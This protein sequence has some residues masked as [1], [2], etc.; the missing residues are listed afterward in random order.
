VLTLVRACRPVDSVL[1]R[2]RWAVQKADFRVGRARVRLADTRVVRGHRTRNDDIGPA[3]NRVQTT[4]VAGVAHAPSCD[5][6][7]VGVGGT[8]CNLITAR[9]RRLKLTDTMEICCAAVAL[10][11]G[12]EL[13]I[14]A[15]AARVQRATTGTTR[16]AGR[17]AAFGLVIPCLFRGITCVVANRSEAFRLVHDCDASLILTSTRVRGCVCDN[18]GRVVAR[19]ARAREI[20]HTDSST[21]EF[22]T[23]PVSTVCRWAVAVSG[24]TCLTVMVGVAG[25]GEVVDQVGA[26]GRPETWRCR[27]LV[28][29]NTPFARRIEGRSSR[30]AESSSSTVRVARLASA[31]IGNRRANSIRRASHVNACI[32][33]RRR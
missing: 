4:A 16:A 11:I 7:A 32:G 25:A 23:R 2:A 5:V 18:W 26:S 13:H 30:R 3:S 19:S 24:R 12:E 10:C 15:R 6:S 33:I 29:V 20:R 17:V 28:D 31:S 1:A 21:R 27:T 22:G 9:R 14:V 8:I